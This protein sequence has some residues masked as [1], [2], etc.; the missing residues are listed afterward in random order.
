MGQHYWYNVSRN[1][2]CK[3]F[4]PV[5]LLYNKNGFLTGF[6]SNVVAQA[7]TSEKL[8]FGSYW[9]HPAGECILEIS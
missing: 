2:D 3:D 4:F 5:F 8:P 6:G 1:M 7:M 9:E